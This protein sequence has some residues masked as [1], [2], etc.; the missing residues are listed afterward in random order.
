MASHL[1]ALAPN[2]RAIYIR[3]FLPVSFVFVSNSNGL[4]PKSDGPQPKSKLYQTFLTFFLVC[5]SNHER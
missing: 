1:R 3:P 2:P 4:P 5:V